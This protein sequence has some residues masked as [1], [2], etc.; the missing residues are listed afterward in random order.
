LAVAAASALPLVAGC[1]QQTAC[2]GF[3]SCGGPIPAG[4]WTLD[5]AHG[6][7]S[8][9]LYTPPVDPRLVNADLPAARQPIPDPAL[10]DWCDLL[11]T[12]PQ[13]PIASPVDPMPKPNLMNSIVG[14]PPNFSFDTFAVTQ[15]TVHYDER[16]NYALSTTRGGTFLVDFPTYC[17]RA[18][19]AI[20]TT[21]DPNALTASTGS[22][23]QKLQATLPFVTPPQFLNIV[24]LTND[25]A[26]RQNLL[27][28]GV[29]IDYPADPGGCLCQVDV[30]DRTDTRGTVL[31]DGADMLHLSASDFPMQVSYCRGGSELAL[32]SVNDA[33]L[34]NRPGL[35]T[36]DL[37][38]VGVN[39][40]DGKRGPGE[41]G[42]D[43][44][45]ACQILCS[46]INCNDAMMG[47]GEAGVDCGPNC[48]KPCPP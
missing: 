7:C 6:S 35:R 14:R 37:V 41:D 34:F 38:S 40:E 9:T 47:P 46:E 39:C 21:F 33:Y 44:G 16:G 24:C 18:F 48:F 2:P 20:D 36:L 29:R 5:S 1:K 17:M 25:D 27:N 28:K 15:A 8:D 26:N 11:V 13:I 43:C 19:G 10:Y 22:V 32:S 12:S 23:C 31:A 30:Q 42:V 45:P 4:D 3:E